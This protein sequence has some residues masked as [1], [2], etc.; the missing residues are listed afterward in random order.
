MSS[1]REPIQHLGGGFMQKWKSNKTLSNSD[2]I[3]LIPQQGTRHTSRGTITRRPAM[4]QMF[5]AGLQSFKVSQAS[6]NTVT[7]CKGSWT[8]NGVK[9]ALTLDGGADYKTVSGFSGVSTTYDVYV[10]LNTGLYPTGLLADKNISPLTP[11]AWGTNV[12]FIIAQVTT[13]SSGNIATI[14]QLHLGDLDDTYNYWDNVSTWYTAGYLTEIKGWGAAASTGVALTTDLILAQATASSRATKFLSISDLSNS[15]DTANLFIQ[16][17]NDHATTLLTKISTS[18][19]NHEDLTHRDNDANSHSTLYWL[20]GGAYTRNYGGGIG[21]T[22][23]SEAIDLTNSCLKDATGPT[24]TVDWQ[25]RQLA[26]GT[27]AITNTTKQTGSATG[28]LQIAGGFSA[29]KGAYI[30]KGAAA[31]AVYAVGGSIFARL[32]GTYAGEFCDGINDVRICSYSGRA[33]TALVG[34][35]DSN[36]TSGFS[37]GGTKVIGAQGAAV[38]DAA[39]GA[40][41]DAEART[42]INTLLAR[43]RTHGLVAT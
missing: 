30:T 36:S 4:I 41:V 39:G 5:S 17:I 32:A 10:Q 14:T 38:A 12:N 20:M 33:I 13:D 37:I 7:V 6:A 22:A 9:V 18:G 15:T 3:R 34:A 21:R 16:N 24:T 23:A 29:E 31:E 2:S 35:I 1:L 25:Q 19:L 27:W 40:T 43:L 11:E 42:A 26:G 28:A 8:R